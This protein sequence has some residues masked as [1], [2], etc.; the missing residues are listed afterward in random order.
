MRDMLSRPSGGKA[1]AANAAPAREPRGGAFRYVR[2]LLRL[3]AAVEDAIPRR[4]VLLGAH[5]GRFLVADHHF[6]L[7][8]PLNGAPAEAE[9]HVAEGADDRRPMAISRLQKG[10]FRALLQLNQ[11]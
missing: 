10:W 4:A 6:L 8:I 7:G 3:Q 11:L 5:R 9:R 1:C 2:F